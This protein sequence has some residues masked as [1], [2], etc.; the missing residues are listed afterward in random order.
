MKIDFVSVKHGN[1]SFR[2]IKFQ[3]IFLP[4]NLFSSNGVKILYDIGPIE[5]VGQSI[6]LDTSLLNPIIAEDGKN[7]ND[8]SLKFSLSSD[9]ATP[10]RYGNLA[11]S[12][13]DVR[14]NPKTE[15]APVKQTEQKTVETARNWRDIADQ[16][17][18]PNYN[19]VLAKC[20]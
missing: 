8:E 4:V 9:G 18:E 13:E 16:L 7:V 10:K 19:K 3:E 20:K 5:K 14:Y 15:I 1:Q 12:G 2:S 6:D 11:I 17:R